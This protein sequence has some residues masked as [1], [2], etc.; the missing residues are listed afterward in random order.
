MVGLD[1]S[2]IAS[3]QIWQSSGHVD[4]FSDPMV[5]CKVGSCTPYSLRKKTLCGLFDKLS[6]FV[7][8]A[9]ILCQN[10]KCVVVSD[11]CNITALLSFETL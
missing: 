7:T 8:E 6:V 11:K 5:D 2:I 10:A 4:G 3:P 1:S 9:L